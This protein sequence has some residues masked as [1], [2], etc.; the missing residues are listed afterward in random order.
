MCNRALGCFRN[1]VNILTMAAAYV[2]DPVD[3]RMK[4]RRAVRYRKRA[5]R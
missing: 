1:D 2:L 5:A 4:D 3:P